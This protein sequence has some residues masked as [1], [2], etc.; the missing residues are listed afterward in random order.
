MTTRDFWSEWRAASGHAAVTLE[1]LQPNRAGDA[2]LDG[3]DE[4]VDG[5]PRR[6]EPLAAV[7]EVGIGPAECVR[8]LLEVGRHHQLLELLVRRVGHRGRGFVDLARLAAGQPR[9]NQVNPS[10]AVQPGDCLE[11]LDH[12]ERQHL[13]AV[14]SD[15]FAGREL[16]LDVGRL[17][18]AVTRRSGQRIESS[19]GS[20]HGSCAGEHKVDRPQTFASVL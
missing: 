19:D 13:D 1:Q 9:G 2:R 7:D 8:D 3:S 11:A 4:R 14:H 15:G 10:N 17:I 16:D 5:R 20:T 12:L 6:R 18:G